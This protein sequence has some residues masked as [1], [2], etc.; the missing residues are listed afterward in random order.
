MNGERTPADNNRP[1]DPSWRKVAGAVRRMVVTLAERG[2][3]Q[4]RGYRTLAELVPDVEVFQALGLWARPPTPATPAA[5]TVE[6]IV[7]NLHDSDAP[8]VVALRDEK[9]RKA[10][11][12]AIAADTTILHNSVVGTYLKPD[13]TIELRSHGGVAV[14]LATKADLEALR[15]YVRNQF[16]N[17]GG[18]T[19]TVVGGS[20]TATL[21]V[22]E[23]GATPPTVD[24]PDPTGTTCVR[25]E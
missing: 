12:A 25:G 22:A 24:P 11:A 2:R 6:A 13:G 23:P 8:V 10:V 14:P 3:W 5:A 18:H 19:H 9:T 16:F 17:V 21:T 7:L 1:N 15:T 4:L 20:T